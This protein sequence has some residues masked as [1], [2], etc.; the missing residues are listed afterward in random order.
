MTEFKRYCAV[1]GKFRPK[2]RTE[3]DCIPCLNTGHIY[4]LVSSEED[5]QE[6]IARWTKFYDEQE[7]TKKERKAIPHFQRLLSPPKPTCPFR[8]CTCELT[9]THDADRSENPYSVGGGHK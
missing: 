1:C 4:H 3:S 5:R 7:F 8:D 9:D 2:G 6:R